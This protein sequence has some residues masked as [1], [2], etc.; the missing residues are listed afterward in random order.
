MHFMDNAWV[1]NRDDLKYL[2]D[3]TNQI[4]L[5]NAPYTPD[6]NSIQLYLKSGRKCSN[7]LQFFLHKKYSSRS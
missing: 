2:C 7:E 5:F 1:N 6:L 4:I 3:E